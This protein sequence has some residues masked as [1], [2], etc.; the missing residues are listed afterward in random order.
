M[1]TAKPVVQHCLTESQAGLLARHRQG[2]SRLAST[3]AAKNGLASTDIL[4]VLADRKGRIGHALNAVSRAG[5]I[6]PAVLPGRAAEL[7]AWVERLAVLGPVSNL[8][9]GSTGIPVI[10]VDRDDSMAVVR[11]GQEST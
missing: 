10:V 4:L 5:S 1:P 3:L 11:L 2:L 9:G 6:G 8:T 7:D